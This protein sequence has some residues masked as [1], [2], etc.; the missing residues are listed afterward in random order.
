MKTTAWTLL[1]LL[2]LGACSRTKTAQD[3]SQETPQIELT[4]ASGE[5]LGEPAQDPLTAE[6][7][8]ESDPLLT[9]APAEAP[10][11]SP[12]EP[13]DSVTASGDNATPVVE[14]L[15]ASAAAEPTLT[16]TTGEYVVGKNETLMMIA[17]KIYGDYA[18]WREIANMNVGVLKGGTQPREGMRL[19][20]SI[21]SEQF[22]W[23]PEG[24]PYL[25]RT[26][27]TLGTISGTVYGTQRRWRALWDN[28][29]PLIKDPHRI[30][31]GF[32]LYWLDPTR[33]ATTD[34]EGAT[35]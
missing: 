18:R 22:N 12:M 29:R 24:N 11:E 17:F 3:V 14:D 30:F 6:A 15:A 25:I 33:L 27:D 7:P 20:Y 28:N 10:V 13:V 16:G 35:L 5:A 32:T 34:S 2:A 4:D 8:L 26:G 21:P 1:A 31:A 19:S 23:N 9:E